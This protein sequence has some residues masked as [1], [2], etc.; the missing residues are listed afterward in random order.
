MDLF[1]VIGLAMV[2]AVICLLLRQYRPE[3]ALLV[4]LG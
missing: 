4:S 2:A 3:Y 1:A